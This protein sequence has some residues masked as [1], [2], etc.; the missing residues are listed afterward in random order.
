MKDVIHVRIEYL[1]K[2]F[3]LGNQ[4]LFLIGS[5]VAVNAPMKRFVT[6]AEK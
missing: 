6:I 3:Q 5:L 2:V 1:L 4:H